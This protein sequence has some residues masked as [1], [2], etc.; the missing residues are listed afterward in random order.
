MQVRLLSNGIAEALVLLE[1]AEERRF[2]TL[3]VQLRIGPARCGHEAAATP[4]SADPS[5][6]VIAPHEPSVPTTA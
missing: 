1:L 5:S 4:R 3:E 6:A 2:L